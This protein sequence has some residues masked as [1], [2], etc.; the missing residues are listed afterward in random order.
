MD[1]AVIGVS[2]FRDR[3]VLPLDAIEQ[4]EREQEKC[5]VRRKSIGAVGINR[6]GKVMTKLRPM[7]CSKPNPY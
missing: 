3:L 2:A 1:I 7:Q 6:F 5:F 4:C